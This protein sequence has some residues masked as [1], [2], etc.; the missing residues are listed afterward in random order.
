[1]TAWIGI[2]LAV[3][4][5]TALF[6]VT[7]RAHFERKAAAEGAALRRDA[8]TLPDRA[9]LAELPAPVRRYLDVAGAAR[10]APVSGVHLRHGGTFRPGLDRPWLPIRGEQWFSAGPP[11][12]VWHG[13]VR[14]GP[15][16][17]I[18]A[19]DRSVEGEGEMLVKLASAFTLQ[20]AR[21]AA[22]DRGALL[23]LLGELAW[24]PTAYLDRRY[25]RWEAVDGDHARATLAVGGRA[26]TATFEFG[27]DGLPAAI[28]GDRERDVGGKS[29][30]TP[31][32]G[33][34]GDFRPVDGLLVPFRMEAV[35]IVDGKPFPYARFE[36]EQLELAPLG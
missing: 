21:G 32:R 2:V 28:S 17:W 12:F 11:G 34:C 6:V 5:A 15:G 7:Q 14:A 33:L 18:D 31:F 27:A 36:V 26:V 30:L 23:R 10:H 8:A 25:V 13:R 4:A 16:V 9:S 20:R 29:V 3:V 35:W 22:L 1:M 24:M 19:R